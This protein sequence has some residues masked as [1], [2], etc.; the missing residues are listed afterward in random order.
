MWVA[1]LRL[2][3]FFV[4]VV[5]IQLAST[6]RLVD[7]PLAS[8]TADSYL[9]C[10]FTIRRSWNDDVSNHEATVSSELCS[11]G[12]AEGS[13]PKHGK[14][15]QLTMLDPLPSSP[16][17]FVYS[18]FDLYSLE[19]RFC[20]CIPRSSCGGVVDISSTY[21]SVVLRVA[22]ERWLRVLLWAGCF[23]SGLC[24]C[25]RVS[26][27]QFCPLE[28]GRTGFGCVPARRLW[29]GVRVRHARARGMRWLLLRCDVCRLSFTSQGTTPYFRMR[30][31]TWF[32]TLSIGFELASCRGGC[33]PNIVHS[34]DFGP[35]F[36][37]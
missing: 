24:V 31:G 7:L 13:S 22:R 15:C 8:H 4:E 9:D 37:V 34:I 18:S 28:V 30:S 29:P 6:S 1:V 33:L 14:F 25:G 11:P 20:F 12:R 21:L 27:S 35:A 16:P 32:R 17:P 2:I 10:W 23:C 3:S 5:F 19:L 36:S 26:L